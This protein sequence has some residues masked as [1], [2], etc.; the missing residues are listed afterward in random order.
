MK[1]FDYITYRGDVGVLVSCDK[2][3]AIIMGI[4][5]PYSNVCCAFETIVPVDM[6]GPYEGTVSFQSMIYRLREY[7]KTHEDILGFM[8]EEL[9][10]VHRF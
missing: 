7:R 10:L 6:I 3:N 9:S 8:S 4:M 5:M 1:E 2:D